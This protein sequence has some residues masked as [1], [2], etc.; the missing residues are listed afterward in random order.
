[1]AAAGFGAGLDVGSGLDV[2]LGVGVGVGLVVGGVDGFVGFVGLGSCEEPHVMMTSPS[3]L[4]TV[5]A[6]TPAV[7]ATELTVGAAKELPPP[8]P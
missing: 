7:R 6:L 4:L 5:P 1:M 3:P 2:G 8:P